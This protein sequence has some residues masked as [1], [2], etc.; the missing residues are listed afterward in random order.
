MGEGRTGALG[1]MVERA[2][3]LEWRV[4]RVRGLDGEE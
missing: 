1:A 4:K 2:T 3:W